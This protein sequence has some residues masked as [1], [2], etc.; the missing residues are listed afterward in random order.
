[1]I[2]RSVV[3][4]FVT[5]MVAVF[6]VSNLGIAAETDAPTGYAS[7]ASQPAPQA[8]TP[9]K[10]KIDPYVEKLLNRSCEDLTLSKAFTFHAEIT[11]DQVLP[12]D[13]KLQFA[14]AADYAVQR[15]D[16]LAVHFHTDLGAKAICPSG[17]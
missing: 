4:L 12:S 13:V 9:P 6:L 15:P 1:M 8:E 17:A 10:S 16:Q 7:P 5:T 14:A 2:N 11:F 3:V